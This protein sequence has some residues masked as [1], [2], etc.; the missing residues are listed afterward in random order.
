M[1]M[2]NSD[3]SANDAPTTD[4]AAVAAAITT[5][6]QITSE[7]NSIP[8]QE[9][10]AID[11]TLPTIASSSDGT[12]TLSPV[13]IAQANLAQI[14]VALTLLAD[15]NPAYDVLLQQRA[16]A[17]GAVAMAQAETDLLA[18]K[19]RQIDAVRTLD[20]A[21]EMIASMIAAIEQHYSPAPAAPVEVAP[22]PAAAAYSGMKQ[23]GIVGQQ[24]N[25]EVAA[26][27]E[28]DP[29]LRLRATANIDGFNRVDLPFLR[30]VEKKAG[31]RYASLVAF[32]G[33]GVT[34]FAD[35]QVMARA[36]RLVLLATGY[37][38]GGKG[39]ADANWCF[40]FGPHAPNGPKAADT[41]RLKFTDNREVAL[42]ADGRYRLAAPNTPNVRFLRTDAQALKAFMSATAA[43][44]AAPVQEV[45]TVTSTAPRMPTAPNSAAAPNGQ[46]MTTARC[47]CGT[48]NFTTD[49]ACRSCGETDWQTA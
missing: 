7:D 18:E 38:D 15:T 30:G 47:G 23:V 16:D 19:Q 3:N 2:G 13:A 42:Y 9:T 46:V 14:E 12:V 6:A 35:Y 28:T 5:G 25:A 33:D 32:G 17:I 20:M 27:L 31:T 34:S 10:I 36:V 24:K 1:P 39:H 26:A 40:A 4:T 21:P 41:L 37:P 43:A 45:T 29:A 11:N 22:A 44:P 49:A 8:M 48:K